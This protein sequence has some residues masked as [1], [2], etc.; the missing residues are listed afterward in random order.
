[1][2]TTASARRRLK[3]RSTAVAAL[4]LGTV[5]YI[6]CDGAVEPDPNPPVA[7]EPIADQTVIS[8][9]SVVLDLSDHFV[10]P[11]GDTLTFAART[12]DAPVATAS[13]SVATLTVRALSTG[14]ATV[15]VT[16]TDP[17]GLS[18]EQAFLAAVPN[19]PPEAVG[20]IPGLEL[21]TGESAGV[22]VADHF[23]D[24]DGGTLTYTA[25]TL[26]PNSADTSN[27]AVSVS[28]A[29]VTIAAVFPGEGTVTVTASDA[30]GLTA[31]QAFAVT[32]PN[33]PPEAV[34]TIAGVELFKY[35]T[36]ILVGYAA[37]FV[38]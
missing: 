36:R 12:S 11:D 15:T 32:V 21:F 3:W 22:D 10:D 7:V 37:S 28:G 24:P 20:T 35:A 6:G 19:R 18:A 1:M 27:V 16:A 31:E 2:T 4:V 23:T 34:G 29:T 13:V 9:D 30:G 25:A 17:G 8:G 38:T 26:D 5:W 33:R 14:Q